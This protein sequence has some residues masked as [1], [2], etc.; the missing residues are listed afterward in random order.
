MVEG[1]RQE[2]V[3][4]MSEGIEQKG[5]SERAAEGGNPH[6]KGIQPR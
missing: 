4:W 1:G 5:K 6:A 3:E 2:E